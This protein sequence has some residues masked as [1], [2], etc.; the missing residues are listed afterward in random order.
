M[1][2][3]VS[4]FNCNSIALTRFHLSLFYLR[5]G[6][7]LQKIF[8]ECRHQTVYHSH[9]LILLQVLNSNK[10]HLMQHCV[11]HFRYCWCCWCW[12]WCWCCCCWWWWSHLFDRIL[13]QY[14]TRY[15]FLCSNW[16]TVHTQHPF[17]ILLG[18]ATIEHKKV[19]RD[20]IVQYTPTD[21]C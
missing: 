19:W 20:R 4:S 17:L 12:C 6:V 5:P 8:V 10:G 1:L 21:F 18:C 2:A 7:L 16:S 14:G 3:V 11:H 13:Q 15:A 9:P